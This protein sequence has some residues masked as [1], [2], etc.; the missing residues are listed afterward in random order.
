MCLLNFYT[1][2]ILTSTFYIIEC[3]SWLIKQNNFRNDLHGIRRSMFL[4]IGEKQNFN[5]SISGILFGD[6]NVRKT[7]N[8]VPSSE[9]Q[10]R[11]EKID[12][13]TDLLERME[14]YTEFLNK[15][16]TGEKTLPLHIN[17]ETKRQNLL[18]TET[19]FAQMKA[20]TSRSKVNRRSIVF[21]SYTV[22]RAAR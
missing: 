19:S 16:I 2:Y 21:S 7:T 13:S 10:T 4:M 1:T 6:I 22:Y 9:G 20:R 11:K 14:K 5:T 12:I 3:I 18:S 17:S 8:K 15:A